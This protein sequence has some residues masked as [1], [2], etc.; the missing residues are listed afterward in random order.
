MA[1]RAPRV[2]NG[3]LQG[4][5]DIERF[6]EQHGRPPAH[7]E[8]NDI[9]ERLYAVRLDKIRSSEECRAVLAGIG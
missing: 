8:G 6:F 3:S 2:R 4:F 1:H 9:F 5:E 7:G